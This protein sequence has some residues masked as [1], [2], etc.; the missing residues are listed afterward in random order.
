ML[1]VIVMAAGFGCGCWSDNRL[2]GYGGTTD[3]IFVVAATNL[4]LMEC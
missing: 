3:S 4:S 1:A 2:I